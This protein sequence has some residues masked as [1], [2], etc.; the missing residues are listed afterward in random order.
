MSG[1]IGGKATQGGGISPEQMALAQYTTGENMV[2]NAQSFSHG[3]GHSTGQSQA[4]VGALFGGAQQE[5]NMSNADAAAQ[6]ASINQQVGQLT[7]GLGSLAGKLGSG[8]GG[9]GGFG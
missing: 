9:G 3:M 1:N 8:G 6:A 7:G 4:N 2:A 5:G